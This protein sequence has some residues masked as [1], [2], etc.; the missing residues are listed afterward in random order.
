MSTTSFWLV[1][2]SFK[3]YNEE[4]A[5]ISNWGELNISSVG[6][7]T[8]QKLILDIQNGSFSK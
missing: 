8:N 6:I 1:N 3:T 5:V 7:V 4:K 2:P